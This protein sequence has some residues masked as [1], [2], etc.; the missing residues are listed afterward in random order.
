MGKLISIILFFVII[1]FNQALSQS[2]FRADSARSH[3]G[4][5]RE[6][7]GHIFADNIRKYKSN[8]DS[9]LCLLYFGNINNT[10]A[11]FVIVVKFNIKNDPTF[12]S[13]VHPTHNEI[14]KFDGLSARGKIFLF[15]GLPAIKIDA[16]ELGFLEQI[17]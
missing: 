5:F 13:V 2:Y 16:N 3:I 17:D 1:S 14:I 15:E 10:K 11:V 8:P 12:S 7:R 6:V 4:E 9:A